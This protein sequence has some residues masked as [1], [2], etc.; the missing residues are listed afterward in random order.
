DRGAEVRPGGRD[1]DRGRALAREREPVPRAGDGAGHAAPYPTR[2]GGGADRGPDQSAA[3]ASCSTTIVTRPETRPPSPV[4]VSDSA[5]LLA[6]NEVPYGASCETNR[7]LDAVAVPPGITW[8][9]APRY[10]TAAPGLA[11]TW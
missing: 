5:P 3:G 6:V 8:R 10:A 2:S 9:F 11:R 1:Q 4:A 7:P